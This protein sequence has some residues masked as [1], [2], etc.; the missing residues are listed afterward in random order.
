MQVHEFDTHKEAMD[1]AHDN[2]G[3]KTLEHVDGKYR[4]TIRDHS[5][6]HRVTL[7]GP[8]EPEEEKEKEQEEEQEVRSDQES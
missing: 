7:E 3:D 4:L 2:E 8:D 1:F 5:A 6:V